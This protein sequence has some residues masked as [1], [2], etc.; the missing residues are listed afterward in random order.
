MRGAE[1]KARAQALLDRLNRK[2]AAKRRLHGSAMRAWLAVDNVKELMT[3]SQRDH[4][5][6]ELEFVQSTLIRIRDSG[7]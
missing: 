7:A 3:D 2:D 1:S 5:R 4:W 6:R